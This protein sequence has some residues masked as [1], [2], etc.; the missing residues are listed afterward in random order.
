LASRYVSQLFVWGDSLRYDIWTIRSA[1]RCP[2]LEPVQLIEL[3]PTTIRSYLVAVVVPNTDVLLEWAEA[4]V[5]T[6]V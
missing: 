1:C 6:L 2:T 3:P 5:A 4:N